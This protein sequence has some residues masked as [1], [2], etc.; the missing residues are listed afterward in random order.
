MSYTGPLS[1]RYMEAMYERWKSDPDAVDRDWQ[2][3]FQGFELGRSEMP[4][5]SESECEPC[6]AES[7]RKQSRVEAL[8][9][10]YRDIGHLLSCLDP[11]AACPTDHP[12]LN[13]GAFG[14]TDDDMNRRFYAPGL[15]ENLDSR[16][17]LRELVDHLRQTYCGSVGVEYMHLQDPDER[18]WLREKMESTRNRPE[19]SRDEKLR[20]LRKLTEAAGFEQFIHRKYLGQK[21]FS[22]EGADVMIPMMDA[23]FVHSAEIHGCREIMLGMTH[24][25]RLNVQTNLLDKPYEAVIREFEDQHNPEAQVGAGD[26][27]YHQ[28][29]RGSITTP[30]GRPLDVIMADN[31]SHLESVNPVVEGMARA[32]L[33][34]LEP[35]TTRQ[36]FPLLLHGD[37]AFSGQGITAETL[38]MS[39]LD[40]YFT[41]GTLHIVINN[42]IGYT[43]LPED[44]RS[45]RYPTDMAKSLMIP[46]FHVHGENPEAAVHTVKLACDYRMAYGKDVVID[47]VCYRRY[48]HNEGDEPYFTQPQMYER[49]KDRPPPDQL[50]ADR[51]KEEA[52]IDDEAIK[53]MRGQS[54]R[55]IQAAY[56]QA[57]QE[58]PQQE[59]AEAGPEDKKSEPQPLKETIQADIRVDAD[60][61]KNMAGKLNSVPDGFQLHR[62]LE[63][64]MEKRLDAVKNGKNIDWANAETLAFAVIASQGIPVRLAGQDSQ[65]GTFSQR[66]S[67]W[68]DT[69]TSRPYVPLNHVAEDQAGFECINSLLS[70][71]GALG[72]EYGYSLIRPDALTLWEAQFGDFVNNAQAIIDLYIAS[73]E[74]KWG[75]QSG[76][77]LL[78]PHGYEGQGPEHSSARIERFL[79][80][81]AEENFFV[82]NPSTPAQYYHL[83]LGQAAGKIRKPLVIFTPKSLLRHTEAVSALDDLAAGDF[84]QVLADPEAPGKP[85]RVVFVSGKLAYEL[86]AARRAGAKKNAAII[87]LEQLHPFPA[88]SLQSVIAMYKDCRDRVWAQEEPANMGAWNYIRPL[89]QKHFSCALSYIGRDAAASTATGYHHV[90]KQQQQELID[91]VLNR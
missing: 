42:Q 1:P 41:G 61:L 26:V 78:L 88:K 43:A 16:I 29:F 51:L 25:G 23:L 90:H 87:R 73:G 91:R 62:K 71:A 11:L 76:L 49:I 14:L 5:P 45:T 33:D 52:L 55:C 56:D 8:V 59:G 35:K 2:F 12:L 86:F 10:R 19:I 77:V 21:R 36:V 67:V 58:P 24:R 60:L 4:K 17:T 75:C 13:P 66:H 6:D 20:I 74:A 31:P 27:K 54:R 44:L 32:R 85:E 47:L 15:P 39:Q 64:L 34:A 68:V 18:R 72:F 84:S 79:Q 40:G 81:A 37:A 3:F 28:G 89:F 80:L 48:G 70:E 9:Y 65:R 57:T 22:A 38:N 46:I 7:V 82:C 63:K 53:N 50:Y 69:A 30:G 83:L